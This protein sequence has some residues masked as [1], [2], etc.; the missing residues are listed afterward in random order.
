M[1]MPKV[2]LYLRLSR[3]DEA[4]RESQSI[5]SQR[6]I[7]Q[8]FL[9]EHGWQ[10]HEVY[11]D[12][13]WSGVQ[14]DRPAF[15]RMLRDIEAGKINIVI[16]KDLSRLG[17]N[18][19]R[20]GELLEEYFPAHGVRYLSASEGYD[21]GQAGGAGE[22]TPF[23]SIFND[24]YARDISRKV[25]AALDA[26]K[27]QG[28]FIGAQ[29]PFGYLR[30]AAQKGKL[31]PDPQTAEDVRLIFRLYLASGSI[32]GTAQQLT[33]RGILPPACRKGLPNHSKT[34]SA[35]T[36]R[37]ILENPT[38]AGHLTQGRV[39]ILSYKVRRRIMLP[40]E[41]W[42]IVRNTHEPLVS[43]ADFLHT[44]QLLKTRSYHKQNMPPHC[45]TGLA[46]CGDCG[47]PMVHMRER[48]RIYLVCQNYRRGN[49]C[50]SHRIREDIVLAA[51]TD[52]LRQIVQ[53]VP[54]E[55]TLLQTIAAENSKTATQQISRA[56]MREQNY[57]QALLQMYM[58]Y[59]AGKLREQEYTTLS[60]EMK[61][62]W[63]QVREEITQLTQTQ[64]QTT[65]QNSHRIQ[66]ILAFHTLE[67]TDAVLF[68]KQILIHQGHGIEIQFRF[69]QP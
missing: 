56:K 30:D 16:T 61:A 41:D 4:G 11:I 33:A 59:T 64:S 8:H 25:R 68:I 5:E 15:Q 2:G 22:F 47:A 34:W 51:I 36:V 66:D 60:S 40:P 69:P 65:A 21:S 48:D 55:T 49:G 1:D 12:D 26:R 45:L 23:I 52:S 37:R 27:Q 46:F 13:G 43:E 57:E 18:Y 50:T 54:L 20:V 42:R 35:Q 38:Y 7:L 9:A 24:M 10:A 32:S 63:R 28:Q 67:R 29:P 6:M 58:D 44:Q 14:F 19:A 3:E 39:R 17:R 53:K 31:I 62:S